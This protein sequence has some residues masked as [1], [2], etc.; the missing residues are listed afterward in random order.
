MVGCLCLSLG[1]LLNIALLA[2]FVY[3]FSMSAEAQHRGGI[4]T[5]VM[6]FV[7]LL[8]AWILVSIISFVSAIFCLSVWLKFLSR[9]ARIAFLLSIPGPLVAVLLCVSGFGISWLMNWRF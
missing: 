2:F 1:V 5:S 6:L 3:V 9:D 8:Y 7:I 4:G